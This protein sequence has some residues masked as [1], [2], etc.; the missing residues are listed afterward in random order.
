LP[1]ER[2]LDVLGKYVESLRSDDHLLLAAAHRE[3]PFLVE[4]A[5]IARAQ[6]S[7][8]ERGAAG[9]VIAGR[10]IL[11]ANQDLSVRR[12]LH[13]DACNRLP[14]GAAARM[15]RMVQRYDR[16]CLSQP[17]SLND[18]KSQARPEL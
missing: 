8:L 11:A 1:V 15:E 2:A 13:L 7:I 17:V 18:E 14:H 6:P 10:D 3:P 9:V 4:R 5:D 16:R 12:D